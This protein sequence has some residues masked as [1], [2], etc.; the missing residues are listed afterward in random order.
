M[1]EEKKE[2]REKKKKSGGKFRLKPEHIAYAVLGVL[3][4]AVVALIV[5]VFA[6]APSYS[7]GVINILPCCQ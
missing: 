5:I 2:A 3:F 4:V 6:A 7:G 1:E